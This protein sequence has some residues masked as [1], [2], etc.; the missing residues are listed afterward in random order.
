MSAC[1]RLHFENG[2][3]YRGQKGM[4]MPG[5]WSYRQLCVTMLVLGTKSGPL[6]QQRDIL[7]LWGISLILINKS[8][9]QPKTCN[10]ISFGKHKLNIRLEY[11]WGNYFGFMS[12]NWDDCVCCTWYISKSFKYALWHKQ[13]LNL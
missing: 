13:L 10:K 1:T 11:I 12:T 3:A 5:N 9:L 7:Y 4:W 6:K 8:F 2:V